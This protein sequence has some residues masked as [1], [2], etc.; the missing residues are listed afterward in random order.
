[1]V[2]AQGRERTSLLEGYLQGAC[3][4]WE[5]CLPGRQVDYALVFGMALVNREWGESLREEAH[6]A[7]CT[8]QDWLWALRSAGALEAQ[9]SCCL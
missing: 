7:R 9:Q 6:T 5:T 3:V 8:A 1:M 4:N 2:E